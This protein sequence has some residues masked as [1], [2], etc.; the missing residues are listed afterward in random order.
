MKSGDVDKALELADARQTAKA[1]VTKSEAQHK[2]ATKAIESAKYALNAE[3]IATIH[4]QVRSNGAVVGYFE[5][6]EQFGVTRLVLERSE[7]TGKIIVN[8]SGPKSPKRS[9]GGGGGGGRGQSL[10]VDG[11]SFDSAS[12]ALTSFRPDFTGK[13]G[14]AAIVSW[15][16]NAGHEVS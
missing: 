1:V 6:L 7:E 14:R 12:A 8:S 10:T 5:A 2:S 4:D 11:Q 15:L 3:K 9:G 13:M 16:I